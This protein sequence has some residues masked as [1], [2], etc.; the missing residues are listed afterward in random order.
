MEEWVAD[1][2]DEYE[3]WY[4][5]SLG[6]PNALL[7]TSLTTRPNDEGRKGQS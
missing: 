4:S 3:T 1:F 6:S 7:T 2:R 5:E